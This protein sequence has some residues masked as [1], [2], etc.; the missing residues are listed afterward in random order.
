[1]A[2]IDVAA[3]AHGGMSALWKGRREGRMEGRRE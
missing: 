1:M 2:L 3:H